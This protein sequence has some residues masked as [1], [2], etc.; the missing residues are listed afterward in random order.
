MN[1]EKQAMGLWCPMVRVDLGKVSGNM[2]DVYGVCGEWNT[3]IASN[4]AMWRWADVTVA[5]RRGTMSTA[6]EL[7][8]EPL[9]E[10]KERKIPDSWEWVFDP[11]E[12]VQSWFEPESNALARR[13][14][15]CGL[16][17]T[18]AVFI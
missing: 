11:E 10:R 4:C 18:P 13:T 7:T 12:G 14:G 5:R 3:C 9:D 15:F 6:F 8:S 2:D 16:A 1:T 17:G